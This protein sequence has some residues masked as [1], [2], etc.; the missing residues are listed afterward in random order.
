MPEVLTIFLCKKGINIS[1]EEFHIDYILE[2]L[3]KYMLIFN[4]INK[5]NMPKYKLTGIGIEE[6]KEENKEN[7]IYYFKSSN[8]KKWYSQSDSKIEN[9]YSLNDIIKGMP[10]FLIYEKISDK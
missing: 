7:F 4:N 10:Y 6:K 1:N 3:D 8:D 9:M 2:D 5:Q